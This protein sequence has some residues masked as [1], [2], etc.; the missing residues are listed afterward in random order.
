MMTL[1]IIVLRNTPYTTILFCWMHSF[2]SE[3]VTSL[4]GH[5]SFA[6][7]PRLSSEF[8]SFARLNLSFCL[9]LKTADWR[10][11][12]SAESS[13]TVCR[14]KQNSEKAVVFILIEIIHFYSNDR[15][16]I[17]LTW[18]DYTYISK[19]II[20]KGWIEKYEVIPCLNDDCA[21]FKGCGTKIPNHLS[22]SCWGFWSIFPTGFTSGPLAVFATSVSFFSGVSFF[23][24]F[25]R[26]RPAKLIYCGFL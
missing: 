11:A 7:F 16:L 22:G 26:L 21:C 9:V 12:I 20:N 14:K 6:D 17:H 19:W 1:Q 25:L 3:T 5:F 15:F 2:C 4:I 13:I 24:L 10:A 8:S 18:K 23:V